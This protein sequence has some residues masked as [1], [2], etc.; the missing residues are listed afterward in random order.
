MDK[1]SITGPVMSAQV[2]FE[3]AGVTLNFSPNSDRKTI[4][5]IKNIMRQALF[6]NRADLCE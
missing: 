1:H 5:R 2:Y 4:D 6:E 3:G